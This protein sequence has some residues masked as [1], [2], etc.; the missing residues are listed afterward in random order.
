MDL[1]TSLNNDATVHHH[2]NRNEFGPNSSDMTESDT[3]ISFVNKIK[4]QR[5]NKHLK[6]NRDKRFWFNITNVPKDS[7][8]I[9]AELRLYRDLKKSRFNSSYEFQMTIFQ[10]FYVSNREQVVMNYVDS[11]KLKGND[12]GWLKFNVTES[13]SEWIRFPN[14]NLGLFLQIR[15]RD[16]GKIR[17][18]FIGINFYLS[19]QLKI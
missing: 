1:Y 2:K 7:E 18:L 11:I 13:V 12:N 14:Q 5:N 3:I 17:V 6:H 16:F 19:F 8:I 15:S 9:N 4:T 10:L